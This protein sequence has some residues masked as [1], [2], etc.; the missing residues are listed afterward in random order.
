LPIERPT[1]YVLLVNLAAANA[2]GITIPDSVLLRAG[3]VIK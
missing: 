1:R 2:L 3:E